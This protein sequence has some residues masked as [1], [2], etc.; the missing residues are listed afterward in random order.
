MYIKEILERMRPKIC[1]LNFIMLTVSKLQYIINFHNIINVINRNTQLI[2]SQSARGVRESYLNS[3]HEK[4][5][6][7]RASARQVNY[8]TEF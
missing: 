4:D 8:A 2:T 3:M 1:N 7:V 5:Q 6:R